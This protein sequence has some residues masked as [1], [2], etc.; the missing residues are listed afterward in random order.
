M[1]AYGQVKTPPC[2]LYLNTRCRGKDFGRAIVRM[3]LEICSDAVENVSMA[4][5]RIEPLAFTKSQKPRESRYFGQDLNSG[6][7]KFEAAMLT[8]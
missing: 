1:K 2:I 3:S 7:S 6:L 4:L 5:T 8:S